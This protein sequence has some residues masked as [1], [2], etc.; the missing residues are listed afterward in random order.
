MRNMNALGSSGLSAEKRPL[1]I[2]EIALLKTPKRLLLERQLETR[3]VMA[4]YLKSHVRLVVMQS[5]KR[6]ILTIPCRWM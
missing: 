5:L 2:I 1:N 6:I 3:F 4:D